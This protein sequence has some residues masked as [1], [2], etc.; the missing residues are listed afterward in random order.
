MIQ[1]LSLAIGGIVVLAFTFLVLLSLPQSKLRDV[2][3]PIVKWAFAI[4][5][6]IYVISP[7]D[8]APEIALGPLGVFDDLAAVVAGIMAAR[9][10]MKPIH[11]E[12]SAN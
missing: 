12:P 9:S 7:M 6:G 1:L 8:L 11:I 10:A 2:L 4:L 3:L 5:C